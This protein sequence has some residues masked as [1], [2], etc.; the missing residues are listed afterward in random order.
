MHVMYDR[1]RNR[2][3]KVEDLLGMCNNRPTVAVEMDNK[4]SD[5]RAHLYNE[6]SEMRLEIKNIKS[7]EEVSVMQK[8]ELRMKIEHLERAMTDRDKRLNDLQE[9]NYAHRAALG[10]TSE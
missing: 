9:E 10:E 4:L 8:K 1:V 7:N 2:L 5:V 6:C 3:E